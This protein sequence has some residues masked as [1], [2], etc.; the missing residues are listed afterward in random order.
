MGK[1][2]L[3]YGIMVFTA[4]AAGETGKR[5]EKTTRFQ[6]LWIPVCHQRYS[7]KTGQD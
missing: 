1:E 5:K 4:T 6:Q 3:W 7:N 2:N